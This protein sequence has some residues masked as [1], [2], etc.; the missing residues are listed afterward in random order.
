[1]LDCLIMTT[2]STFTYATLQIYHH[3]SIRA[4]RIQPFSCV[5]GLTFTLACFWGGRRQFTLG[6][7]ERQKSGQCVDL[8]LVC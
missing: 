5:V 8:D 2:N 6:E 3:I 7:E 4:F 1:M